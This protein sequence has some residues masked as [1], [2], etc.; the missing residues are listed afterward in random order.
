MKLGPFPYYFII[1]FRELWQSCIYLSIHV[2]NML[3]MF[4]SITEW[5][6][7][8]YFFT[9]K[10]TWFLCLTLIKYIPKMYALAL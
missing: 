5:M 9:A 3:T 8:M 2:H 6:Y 7:T 10:A 4:H 1:I